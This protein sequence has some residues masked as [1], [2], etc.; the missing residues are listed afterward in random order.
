M[1]QYGVRG[2]V[3]VYFGKAR[4]QPSFTWPQQVHAE[5][6]LLPSTEQPVTTPRDTSPTHE[7]SSS[8]LPAPGTLSILPLGKS[9]AL[10]SKSL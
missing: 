10:C 9:A 8:L 1:E 2:P 3:F 4:S 5:P 6:P 7:H